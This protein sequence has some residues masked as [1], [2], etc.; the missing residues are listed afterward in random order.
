[1][2][3]LTGMAAAWSLA[4]SKVNSAIT[5]DYRLF[6]EEMKLVFDHPVK[7]KQAKGWL[8]DLHQGSLSVSQYAVEFRILAAESGWGDSALQAVFFKRLSEV[9]KDDLATQDECTSLN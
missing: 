8:L 6:I 4:T 1:M 3:L 2:S 5:S 9:L 7:G